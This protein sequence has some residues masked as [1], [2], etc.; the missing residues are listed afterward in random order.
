MSSDAVRPSDV[1]VQPVGRTWADILYSGRK[2]LLII[3]LISAAVTIFVA[4]RP[5]L[6][7]IGNW[8][9]ENKA[10]IEAFCASY[11]VFYLI[12]R[13]LVK[14]LMAV[15]CVDYLVLD[16]VNLKGAVYRI[17]VPLL[18]DFE[19]SGGN[20][21]QF[22]WRDGH[23][24]KLARSVDIEAGRIDT[25]WPHEVPIEQ[26]AFTLADLQSREKDYRDCKIENLLLRRR[27]VVV[28]ADLARESNDYLAHELSDVLSIGDLDVASYLDGLDPLQPRRLSDDAPE[29]ASPSSTDASSVGS[30]AVQ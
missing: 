29:D 1:T 13:W 19:V 26:A 3:V 10:A 4:Y 21:L 24:F 5:D 2:T 22:A 23:V 8:I 15:Q 17:P 18:A 20:N 28:A 30:G 9:S 14:Q 16:F 25:A 27:P 7:P 12:G 6:S 11:I